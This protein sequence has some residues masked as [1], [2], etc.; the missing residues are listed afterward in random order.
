[1]ELKAGE[2]G[3]LQNGEEI[4]VYQR[5]EAGYLIK[6]LY[7][8]YDDDTSDYNEGAIE[9]ADV[10][11]V[12]P[13]VEIIAS[14][15]KTLEA[16]KEALNNEISEL[17]RLKADEQS[18]LSKIAK[19]EGLAKVIDYLNED[20]SFVVYDETNE[21]RTKSNTYWSRNLG[22][23]RIKGEIKF[24]TSKSDYFG[25]GLKFLTPFKTKEEAQEHI[26]NNLLQRINNITQLY[27]LN[28]LHTKYDYR[29]YVEIPVIK[30]SI[31]ARRVIL[32][33]QHKK[34]NIEAIEKKYLE[35]KA[36]MTKIGL[37]L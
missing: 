25:S 10:V 16:K 4:V 15:I 21:L 17:K 8:R 36:E 30:S 18:S 33:E 31:K 37:P 34:E 13:P 1:M 6:R 2:K 14:E 3:Y 22:I 5:I 27:Y 9:F 20:F 29:E 23:E 35:A 28:E 19:I 11:F 26:I 12:N 7:E 32:E 24:G